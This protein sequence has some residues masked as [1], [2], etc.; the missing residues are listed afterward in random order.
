[1][2]LLVFGKTNCLNYSLQDCNIQVKV[3]V[4]STHGPIFIVVKIGSCASTFGPIG[5]FYTTN[6]VCD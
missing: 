1:M 5:P 6:I 4:P 3:F 2:I